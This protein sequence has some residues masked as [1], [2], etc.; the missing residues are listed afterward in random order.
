MVGLFLQGVW[1][2]CSGFQEMEPGSTVLMTMIGIYVWGPHLGGCPNY[3][4]FMGTLN[5]G[6]IG[7]IGTILRF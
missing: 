1:G 3:G 4:P 7:T 2:F 5:I 6:I